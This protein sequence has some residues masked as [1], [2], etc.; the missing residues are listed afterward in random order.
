MA[1]EWI[2]SH[3]KE[4]EEGEV[5]TLA[6]RRKNSELLGAIDIRINSSDKHGEIG[7][8][9]GLPFWGQGIGTEA[10]E[11][12][13][14]YGFQQLDLHRIFAHHLTR[15]PASGKIMEKIGMQKE[16]ILREHAIKWGKPEDLA[17]WGMLKTDWEALQVG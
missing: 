4:W 7:Y 10:A 11:A 2:S 13:V 15:N 1:E 6:I 17:V 3:R 12:M 5:L 9:V 16:G 8:W 14:R